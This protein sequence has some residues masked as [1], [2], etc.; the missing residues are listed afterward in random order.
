MQHTLLA[1]RQAIDAKL[2]LLSQHGFDYDYQCPF[3]ARRGRSGT[4]HVR[5][6]TEKSTTGVAICHNCE[7]Q[8]VDLLR[9]IRDIYGA[10]PRHF[11]VLIRSAA[12]MQDVERILESKPEQTDVVTLPETFRRIPYKGSGMGRMLRRY[13]Y[14]RGCTYDDIDRYNLGYLTDRAHRAYGYVIFP[15]YMGGKC[16]YWQGRRVFSRGP[17]SFNPPSTLN[18]A[19]LFGY[20]QTDEESTV[21]VVEGPLDAI[22]WGPGGLSLSRKTIRPEQ[23]RALSIL[24]PK[25]AIVCMDGPKAD[26]S[27]D[28]YDETKGIARLLSKRLSCPTGYLLLRRGDPWDNRRRLRRLARKETVWLSHKGDIVAEVKGLI[29]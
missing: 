15:F 9:L 12:F 20:D 24:Q 3:C 28:A 16:V 29:G 22:A 14:K 2:T 7:W 13:L 11:D 8:T 10:V 17:K 27:D 5:Y 23:V 19:Y 4:L 26:G 25:R 6:E 1:I 18:R 21:F